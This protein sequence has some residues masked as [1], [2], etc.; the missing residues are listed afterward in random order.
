MSKKTS[1]NRRKSQV[2]LAL[3]AGYRH[4]MGISNLLNRKG[5]GANPP[6]AKRLAELTSTDPFLWMRGGSLADRRA[7]VRAWQE[8]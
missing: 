6:Y 3:L 2:E 7:A 8:S 1:D 5:N 4:R